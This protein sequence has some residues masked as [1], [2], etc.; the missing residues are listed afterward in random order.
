MEG[1][2]ICTL[3]TTWILRSAFELRLA[4]QANLSSN[5]ASAKMT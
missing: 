2:D 1:N 5:G 4:R 3:W